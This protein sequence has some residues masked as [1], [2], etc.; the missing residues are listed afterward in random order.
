M[1][2]DSAA[3]SGITAS[4]ARDA[5]AHLDDDGGRL[6]ERM[7]TPWWYHPILGLFVAL[8]VIAPALGSA[9]SFVALALGVI[10]PLLLGAVYRRRYGI[11][12]TGS[13]AGI[14]ILLLVAAILVLSMLAGAF[15]GYTDLPPWWAAVPA[16]VAFG[17]TVL[18]GRRY[19][20]ALRGELAGS[21][22]PRP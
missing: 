22:R 4:E 13:G 12:P 11:W 2:N 18:L 3:A 5:L 6:A 20:D 9:L 14:G 8:I 1:E 19:D 10:G 15:I 7:V 21:G 16:A 17:A